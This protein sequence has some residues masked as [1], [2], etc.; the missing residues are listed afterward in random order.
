M[1]GFAIHIFQTYAASNSSC[2]RRARIA[3]LFILIA[4]ISCLFWSLISFFLY[5]ND[6]LQNA[7][8]YHLLR[9]DYKHNFSIHFYLNYL[10]HPCPIDIDASIPACTSAFN[11]D[12]SFVASAFES[13]L[14]VTTG[15]LFEKVIF[16]LPQAVIILGLALLFAEVDLP[17]CLLL[18]TMVFVTYNKVI[19]AQYF[20]WYAC[21][22]PVTVRAISRVPFPLA[23]SVVGCWFAALLYWLWQAYRLE[24]LGMN[25]F[26]NIWIGS[27]LFFMSNIFAILCLMVCNHSRGND[28]E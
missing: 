22:L 13:T 25:T 20:T 12:P 7:V 5:G 15:I 3:T 27:I 26:E 10:T 21:F 9:S 4:L 19:T 8:L 24:F 6:Y 1:P 16:F 18:Q 17:L 28:S 11:Y 2:L 14:K 23:C